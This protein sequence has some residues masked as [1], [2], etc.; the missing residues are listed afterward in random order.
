MMRFMKFLPIL[1]MIGFIVL[2]ISCESDNSTEPKDQAPTIP[3]G[4]TM[5]IDFSEFPDTNSISNPDVASLSKNNWGWAALN[6]SVW[7]SLLTL[8]LAFPV[9]AFAESFNHQPV[10]HPDGSWLWQYI[11]TS[12]K[13]TITVKLFGLPVTT[14]IEWR[15]LLTAGEI[16]NFEWFTGFSNANTTE[17]NW[18]LFKDLNSPAPFLFIEWHRNPQEGTAD[19]KYTNITPNAPE[20]GSYIHYG[21]TNE[22]P[23]NRFYNLYGSEEDR[24]LEIKWNFEQHFGRVKDPIHFEDENWHCWDDKLEDIDCLE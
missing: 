19:V 18:T 8:T 7:N 6:V 20:N 16:S 11:V 2:I 5:M 22:I 21:K 17:G 10:Q 4:S 13:D 14:G 1:F 23:H 9:A 24:L 15:M 12:N 3:P